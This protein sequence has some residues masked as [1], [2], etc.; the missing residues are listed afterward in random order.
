MSAPT[1]EMHRHHAAG[2]PP[3]QAALVERPGAKGA[4]AQQHK[5]FKAKEK[6]VEQLKNSLKLKDVRGKGVCVMVVCGKERAR[7]E[8][9]NPTLGVLDTSE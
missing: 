3:E 9:R 2:L 6:E 1:A 4:A 8:R 7:R 5:R